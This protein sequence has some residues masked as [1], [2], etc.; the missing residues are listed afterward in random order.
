MGIRFRCHHCEHEL[1]LK[2]FQAG[3]RA[4]CPACSGKF[5]VPTASAD[6]SVPLDDQEVQMA[7][8]GTAARQTAAAAFNLRPSSSDPD[9]VASRSVANESTAYAAGQATMPAAISEAPQAVWYVR[10]PSGGQ[11]G[12]ADGQV[13]HGWL[14]DNRVSP[15]SLVWRDGWP[16]WQLAGDVFVELFGDNW[17]VASADA[18]PADATLAQVAIES[19]AADEPI[20]DAGNVSNIALVRR[21]KKQ[22]TYGIFIGVLAILALVLIGVLATVLF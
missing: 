22:A 3:R 4:R 2:E 21:K 5:R 17:R 12:P 20:E 19:Q 1:N 6:F 13:F 10:P 9:V 16:Q 8:S 14:Q 18:E 15:D 7:A 11:Y